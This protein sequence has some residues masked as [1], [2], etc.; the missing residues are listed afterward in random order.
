MS[1]HLTFETLLVLAP[2]RRWLRRRRTLRILAELDERQLRD[3]GLMREDVPFASPFKFRGRHKCYRALA[4][5]DDTQLSN[6]SERGLQVRR[7]TRR[8][9]HRSP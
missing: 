9:M 1:N 4:E 3:I 2:F 7:E 6:L 5:L 8:A